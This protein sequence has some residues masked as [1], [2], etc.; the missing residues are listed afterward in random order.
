V[1]LGLDIGGSALKA[2]KLDEEG[3]IL[4]TRIEL[5]GG[6]LPREALL[7]QIKSVV[8]A[9]A[10]GE[11]PRHVGL[12]IGGA[13]QSDGTM[14]ATSTNLPNL[15]GLPL[16]ETFSAL[17]G[18]PCRVENDARAAMRGEAWIGAAKGLN[19]AMVL[20]FGSG[21][22]AGLLSHGQIVEGAHRKA[23]EIGLWHLHAK[24]TQDTWLTFEDLAAPVRLG[25]REKRDFGALFA[26]WLAGESNAMKTVIETI[27]CAI[28]NA[29]LM[30]DLEAAI[31]LGGIAAIGEPLRLAVAEAFE[32]ACP[33]DF[34][35]GIAVRLGELGQ[36]A[37]AIGAASLWRG[38]VG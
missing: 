16:V 3:T 5:A 32:A 15:A 29:H 28:A 9:L 37:G 27:G 14:Q 19:H 21:I 13:I 36:F 12:A 11:P 1:L 31:L 23:G 34:Q 26:G 2:A 20:T 38:E 18:A 7:Q 22:G 17:L 8:D 25:D 4:S 30:L 24:P 6:R 10:E 35:D 33:R